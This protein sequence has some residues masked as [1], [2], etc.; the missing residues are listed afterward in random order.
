MAEQR[1]DSILEDPQKRA[2]E[3]FARIRAAGITSDE[4][5]AKADEFHGDIEAAANFFEKELDG[6]DASNP[7]ERQDPSILKDTGDDEK[8]SKNENEDDDPSPFKVGDL[9]VAVDKNGTSGVF[10]WAKPKRIQSIVVGND[11]VKYA[12][13]IDGGSY[14]FDLLRSRDEAINDISQA[15]FASDFDNFDD[16]ADSGDSGGTDAG[17][18]DGTDSPEERAARLFARFQ[19]EGITSEAIRAKAEELGGDM[20]VTANFFEQLLNTRDREGAFAAFGAK[21]P[22]AESE[23]KPTAEKSVSKLGRKKELEE[24]K[25]SGAASVTELAE[26]DEISEALTTTLETESSKDAY[27]TDRDR[28]YTRIKDQEKRIIETIRATDSIRINKE[29]L[30]NRFNDLS[31]AIQGLREKEV[32]KVEE[33]QELDLRA[34][35]LDIVLEKARLEVSSAIEAFNPLEIIKL[36]ALQDLEKPSEIPANSDKIRRFDE[37]D[38]DTRQTFSPDIDQFKREY[39]ALRRMHNFAVAAKGRG[40][41]EVSEALS[42]TLNYEALVDILGGAEGEAVRKMVL[43]RYQADSA[44]FKAINNAPELKSEE[45]VRS[46]L[47]NETVLG[48]EGRVFVDDDLQAQY[49][50]LSSDEQSGFEDAHQ[51]NWTVGFKF[52]Q[53]MKEVFVKS[54]L[55]AKFLENGVYRAKFAEINGFEIDDSD[56]AK[57]E[58]L[59]DKIKGSN[60]YSANKI[61]FEQRMAVARDF[62]E[63]TIAPIV[64]EPIKVAPKPGDEGTKG[65]AGKY[66]NDRNYIF[67]GNYKDNALIKDRFPQWMIE[68]GGNKVNFEN[69]A[70]FEH[71]FLRDGFYKYTDPSEKL[72]AL[73]GSS[74]LEEFKNIDD[75]GEKIKRNTNIVTNLK[76]DVYKDAAATETNDMYGKLEA[77]EMSPTEEGA[78]ALMDSYFAKSPDDRREFNRRVLQALMVHKMSVNGVINVKGDNKPQYGRW[79]P[80]RVEDYLLKQV[81]VYLGKS[82]MDQ[83]LK[84]LY[85]GKVKRT[86]VSRPAEITKAFAREVLSPKNLLLNV[87][88]FWIKT[89][90][91]QSKD[92]IKKDL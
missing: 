12:S 9:V 87:P 43:A 54:K 91:N 73:F 67:A 80:R 84:E 33:R 20:E 21:P 32:K 19:A 85:G 2:N 13:F 6:R 7:G 57:K 24:R 47:K 68:A 4:I 61:A 25:S 81:P 29:E 3:L 22:T 53:Q 86:F 27:R 69:Q 39:E 31:G 78:K 42:S 46:R 49:V 51:D 15:Y 83:L 70:I 34:D 35:A 16:S 30:L 18:S 8:T 40:A 63:T 23:S 65:K 88:V 38:P 74:S 48:N 66:F 60:E 72:M 56:S 92:Q 17:G 37:L 14:R 26:L 41:K 28:I 11:G 10:I 90:F 45:E 44:V 82:E 64:I 59:T 52:K 75:F 1:E 58:A 50:A 5:R 89:L 77:F 55:N 76:D 36:R 79:G 71:I 62:Y